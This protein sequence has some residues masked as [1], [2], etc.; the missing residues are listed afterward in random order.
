MEECRMSQLSELTIDIRAASAKCVEKAAW[1][2]SR[3]NA[4]L[5]GAAEAAV[6]LAAT[7]GESTDERL[8]RALTVFLQKSPARK[9]FCV[10]LVDRIRKQERLAQDEYALAQP[11][12]AHQ[13]AR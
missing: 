6:G 11:A 9:R 1:S 3:E 5:N 8:L 13:A 4:F 2:L 12:A 10:A 7:P